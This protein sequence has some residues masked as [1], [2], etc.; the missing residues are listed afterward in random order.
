MTMTMTMTKRTDYNRY[1]KPVLRLHGNARQRARAL[2]TWPAGFVLYLNGVELKHRFG[3]HGGPT[4]WEWGDCSW[5][6]RI[7]PGHLP[8][9]TTAR[10]AVRHVLALL[11]AARCPT[12]SSSLTIDRAPHGRGFWEARTFC[13]RGCP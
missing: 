9:G 12:C 3:G 10:Q 2:K 4:E 11:R 7:P 6:W 8:V 5:P 13:A 1:G